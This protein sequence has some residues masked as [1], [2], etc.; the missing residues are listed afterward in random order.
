[1]VKEAGGAIRVRMLWLTEEGARPA[2]RA[3][4]AIE[5]D[6]EGI[7]PLTEVTVYELGSK[8]DG[9][10]VEILPGCRGVLY[11]F[12]GALWVAPVVRMSAAAFRN[13]QIET[14]RKIALQNAK[15]VAIAFS[16]LFQDYQD[17]APPTENVRDAISPY[18]RFSP[19]MSALSDFTFTYRGGDL[20]AWLR[21]MP[22]MEDPANTE[23]GIMRGPGGVA[24]V[25]ADGHVH[26]DDR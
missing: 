26:C 11:E 6:K 5:G 15:Q 12:K 18:L 8:I 1:M 25:Y 4:V 9:D 23:I 21:D 3:L 7:S 22:D 13:A 20:L 2:A 24:V 14:L 16:C 19:A 17:E 10:K